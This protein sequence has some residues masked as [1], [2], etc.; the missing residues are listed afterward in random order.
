M[1][2]GD[3]SG[4]ADTRAVSNIL[5]SI[6]Q[7]VALFDPEHTLVYWN[8]QCQTA[9][10]LPDE[11]VRTGTTLREFGLYLAE[12]GDYGDGDPAALVERRMK[13]L[14]SGEAL[15]GE[16]TVQG[17]RTYESLFQ[18]LEDGGLV[19]TYTDV[20]E[21]YQA[22]TA[23]RDS[24]ARFKDFADA[25]S[26]WFW[27][28]DEELRFVLITDTVM[29]FNGGTDPR[30]VY[31]L[32]RHEQ[33]V[34]G[35]IETGA[36][37]AHIADMEAH[38][39]FKDFEYDFIDAQ[40]KHHDWSISGRPFFDDKGNFRGYRGIG[41]DI[42]ERKAMEEMLRKN[43]TSL[44]EQILELRDREERLESQA[45]DIVAVAEDLAIAEKRMQFL[46]N[47]DALTGL[48][49]IRLC[50]DRIE[51]A[52]AMAQRD[53]SQCGLMFIDLDGFTLGHEA[54]DIILKTVADRIQ[55]CTREVDTAGRIGGDEFIIV[56]PNIKKAEHVATLAE[57]LIKEISME[58]CANPANP[59]NGAMAT[60]GASIGIALFPADGTTCDNLIKAA[61]KSMYQVKR[62]GKNNYG[63]ASSLL[64]N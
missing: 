14:Q 54:G 43:Q 45:A 62:Q 57:R 19:I 48:P 49:S 5:N 25:A 30:S 44:E 42:S 28:L 63:F 33:N 31:G 13:S 11:L 61:D 26:D 40:G 34:G 52:M 20:T 47:H 2:N 36:W 27:E 39:P 37:L 32:R 38:R 35:N 29:Q 3:S 60:V 22:S 12:R 64:S 41:R 17:D 16:I 55:N 59:S 15:R 21:H 58:M 9:L 18:H 1:R 8:R 7:G 24:E 53:Q 4:N 46:A 50:K 51:A 56:L 10:Q 6:A 23:L